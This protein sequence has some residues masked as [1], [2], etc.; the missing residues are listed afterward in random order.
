MKRILK[1]T[2]KI[3]VLA[4]TLL[5]MLLACSV[6]V[7]AD[8]TFPINIG[9]NGSSS[10]SFDPYDVKGSKVNVVI[11]NTSNVNLKMNIAVTTKRTNIFVNSGTKLTAFS[12]S[13]AST[14]LTDTKTSYAIFAPGESASMIFDFRSDYNGGTSFEIEATAV[15]VQDNGGRNFNLA[16][17]IPLSGSVDGI[18]GNASKHPE[19]YS[20]YFSIYTPNRRFFTIDLQSE[21]NNKQ[22]ALFLTKNNDPEF[23]LSLIKDIHG[24]K[25]NFTLLLD[26]GTYIIKV[27]YVFSQVEDFTTYK[28]NL[29]GRDYIPATGVSLTSSPA[30]LNFDSRIVKQPRKITFTAATIPS[31]SDDKLDSINSSCITSGD[32]KGRNSATFTITVS[33]NRG[34][35]DCA[36]DRV[37]V[38]ASNGVVSNALN[39]FI[40]PQKPDTSGYSVYY[41]KILWNCNQYGIQWK[42]EWTAKNPVKVYIKSGKSWKLK[43]TR[44][45][46]GKFTFKKLKSNKKYQFKFVQMAKNASGQ[47]IDGDPAYVNIKTTRKTKLPI[48]SITVGKATLK[49]NYRWEKWGSTWTW[50]KY[51]Y[52][53][54]PVTV[55]RSKRL[56]G[57]KYISMS[58][59]KIKGKGNK[60]T[61]YETVAGNRIGKTFKL[62]MTPCYAKDDTGGYGPTIKRTIR[63]R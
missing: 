25:K 24:S 17:P 27:A 15:T 34:Y 52:T 13:M 58:G 11:T 30:N 2:G 50:R 28:M 40:K 3:A 19:L 1:K 21:S 42:P 36:Y 35:Y 61:V 8:I 45:E 12:S 38:K 57:L 32:I 29:S 63:I 7:K 6:G 39:I 54:F 56:P 26:P 49:N 41:N 60:F 59:A 16:Q 18:L 51:S 4:A 44:K 22:I 5:I 14:G 47:W 9:V 31:N 37:S 33:A 62:L 43:T 55:R 46:G 23:R 53:R 20:R 10:R 48:Q